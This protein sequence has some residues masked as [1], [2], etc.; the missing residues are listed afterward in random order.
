MKTRGVLFDLYGTLI[1]YGEMEKA[2]NAWYD[3]IFE[4]FRAN[5]L[6]LSQSE[7]RPFCGG[8]FERPEPKDP[9]DDLTVV[10]RRLHRLAGK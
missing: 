8:F 3:V 7:F 9:G 5:G 2:W 4:V 10:E 6:E 1:V